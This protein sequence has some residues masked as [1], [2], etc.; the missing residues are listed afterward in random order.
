MKSENYFRRYILILLLF[1]SIGA[2]AQKSILPDGLSLSNQ[3]EYS[4]NTE[5]NSDIFENWFNLDYRKSVFSAGIRFDVFQPNDPDP[6]ISRGK[7]KYSDISFKYFG[8][9]LG[10]RHKG[11]KFTVGNY[12]EMFGR[13][14]LLKSYED[15]NIR[16]DNNLLGVNLKANYANFYLTA[17]TGSAE[18][19]LSERKDILHAVDL[20]YRGLKKVKLGASYVSNNPGIENIASTNL[21]SIR[22]AP[23]IWN[24]EFYG[25]YGIKQNSDTKEQVFNNSEY[26]IGEAYYGNINFYWGLFSISGE[27]KYYDNFAFQ[28]Y[29]K[30]IVYNTPPSLRRDQTYILLNR[31]PSALDQNNETGFQVEA[32]YN[33]SSN[34][35]LLLNYNQTKTLPS[36]SYYQRIL[37]TNNIQKTQLKDLYF[38][39]TQTWNSKIE[40]IF[41]FDINEE[42]SGNTKSYTPILDNKFYIGDIHTLRIVFE[43]QAVENIS[44]NEKYYDQVLQ[45]EYLRSPNI[46]ISVVTEMKT[47]E[48]EPNKVNRDFWGFI[49]FGYKLAE[50]TDLSLLVGTRQAGNIC[51]GGVCRY[52]PEFEGLELKILTRLY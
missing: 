32:N 26:K 46:S 47:T 28:S 48:P 40:T 41:A 37:E 17:L 10:N 36:S 9:K 33:V 16:I 2:F 35:I 34:S 20:E 6:S 12:Y 13:G 15:R 18:N 39:L 3:L 22:F 45:L 29:D 23:R 51:I 7:D 4:H 24:F 11:M 44:N 38:Q 21:S 43:H 50:H 25:E 30:T 42:L 19:I 27:Y 14:L 1:S 52:E 49:M 5:S 8:I 31:H